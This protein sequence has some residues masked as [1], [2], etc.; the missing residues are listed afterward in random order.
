MSNTIKKPIVLVILDGYGYREDQQDNA[1]ALAN[2]PN[3][4]NLIKTCPNTLIDASSMEVGLPFGQMG[5]SE[6]GHTNIGAGRIVYQD[7]TR[8]SKDIMDGEFAKNLVL[9][10]AIDDTIAQGKAVHIMGLLSE[11]GV[12]SHEEHIMA[13]VELAATRGAEKIYLHAFLDGRD[14]PPRSAERSLQVFADKFKALGK[15]RIASLIGRYY[16]MD[17]DNRWDRVE[18]AY[19]LLTEA[20]GAFTYATAVEGLQA[21]YAR[22]ENDE[23]GRA[24]CR[25]RV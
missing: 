6:V 1:I 8:V 7:L 24:S 25:E 19:N 17:R 18:Q 2:K 14:T 9:T 15:G 3:M 16:A 21:A 22:D 4:D 20:D 5:N 10:Q 12:H 13:M 23:I 11:G